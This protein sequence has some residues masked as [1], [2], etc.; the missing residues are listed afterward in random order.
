MADETIEQA[1][2]L[3]FRRD[4]DGTLHVMLV[5][6]RSGAWIAPKGHIDEGHT[7]AETARKEAFEEA[8]VQGHLLN[9]E[10]GSYSYEKLGHTYRVELFALRVT[11]TLED[12]P[13]R[14]ERDRAWMTLAEARRKVT[15]AELREALDRLKSLAA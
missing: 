14:G 4:A 10:L 2:A 3:P 5:K 7:P 13:E 6:S 8:G 15:Y 9:A 12:W 1:G 11:R